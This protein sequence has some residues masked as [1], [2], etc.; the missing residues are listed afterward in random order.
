L[1]GEAGENFNL[2]FLL[3]IFTNLIFS[4][5]KTQDLS[6]FEAQA[7]QLRLTQH[8]LTEFDNEK[9]NSDSKELVDLVC[10]YK[11]NTSIEQAPR[12]KFSFFGKKFG[13]E[14]FQD[15]TRRE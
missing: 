3:H 12:K 4:T 5:L 2:N 7:N 13:S 11:P 9:V 14:T 15:V 10:S 8:Y 1:R 6:S